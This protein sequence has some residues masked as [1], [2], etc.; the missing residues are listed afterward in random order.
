MIHSVAIEGWVIFVSNVH[1]EAQEEDIRDMFGEFG[2]IANLHL[3]LDRR[4][5]FVKGYVLI[6]YKERSEAAMAI[7]KTNGTKLLGRAISVDWAFVGK[8]RSDM[9]KG[10]KLSKRRKDSC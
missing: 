1:E 7:S 4:T 9:V 5:G 8:S 3:N 2:K 10:V 6:E